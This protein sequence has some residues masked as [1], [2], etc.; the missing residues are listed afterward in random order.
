[1]SPHFGRCE[2]FMLVDVNPDSQSV[3]QTQTLPAPP[4]QPGLLPT[5]LAEQGATVIIAAGM[6]SRAQAL[7]SESR[8]EVVL[9]DAAGLDPHT[10][11]RAFLSGTLKVGHNIC[12]H[13]KQADASS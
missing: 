5:W 7:F 9:T 11:F 10:L 6:G 4:H 2:E 13:L 1:M 3:T 12:D 8:M